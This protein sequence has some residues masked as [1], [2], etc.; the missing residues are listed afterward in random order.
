MQ[1]SELFLNR[2]SECELMAKSTR[3]PGNKAIW[4]RMA[5]RWHRYAELEISASLAAAQHGRE[6][7]RKPSPGWSR[8]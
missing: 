6:R 8:H 7:H 3:D 5:E 1:T 4:M 2:A